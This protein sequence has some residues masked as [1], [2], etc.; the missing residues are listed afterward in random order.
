[1]VDSA[2]KSFLWIL[3]I[4]SVLRMEIGNT[5]RMGIVFFAENCVS[6]ILFELD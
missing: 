2:G 6:W 4:E 5:I 1:M 3:A